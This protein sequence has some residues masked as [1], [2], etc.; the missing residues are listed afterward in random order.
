[1]TDV[2]LNTS[3][4]QPSCPVFSL[5]GSYYD[6]TTYHGRFF[7]IMDQIDPRTL[8]LSA[9]EISSAQ[10]LLE[11][12]ERGDRSRSDSELWEAKKRVDAAVH[13]SLGEVREWGSHDDGG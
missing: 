2:T 7:Q 5:K 4:E 10:R 11:E 9:D 3:S 6:M 1:M 12:F 8:L 13:P